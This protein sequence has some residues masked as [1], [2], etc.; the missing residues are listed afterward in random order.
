MK[1]QVYF[2]IY[3][4]DLATALQLSTE[5]FY[6]IALIALARMLYENQRSQ[7]IFK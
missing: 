2:E 6:P 1:A 3:L 7:I 4:S 5:R